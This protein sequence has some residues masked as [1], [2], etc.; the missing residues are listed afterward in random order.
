MQS[1]IFSLPRRYAAVFK[2]KH[3]GEGIRLN[4]FLNRLGLDYFAFYRMVQWLIHL[5]QEGI[6]SSKDV[7]DLKLEYG[8]YDAVA[9]LAEMMVNRQ[10]IGEV[11]AQGPFEL[12]D[13]LGIDATEDIQFGPGMA[14]GMT[15][16]ID[17]RETGLDPR[18]FADVVRPRPKHRHQ[19]TH[20]D[21][22]PD[23]FKDTYWP[24]RNRSFFDVKRDFEQTMTP[25]EAEI[26]KIFSDKSFNTGR[27]EKHAGDTVSVCNCLGI[28]DISPYT[29]WDP[30]RNI[31]VLAD[32]Y[33]AVTG[34]EMASQELKKI[35]ERAMDMERLLNVR[36]GFNREDDAFPKEWLLNTK[37]PYTAA[38]SRHYTRTGE[39]YLT[40]FMGKRL[41]RNDLQKMLDDYYDERGWDKDTGIPTPE[42]L[43]ELGLEEFVTKE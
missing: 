18:V 41:S 6:I 12:M 10:G 40:D 14:K 33:S 31:P 32:F 19:A 39:C 17:A 16:W 23:L 27:L 29:K 36:E 5:Y 3:Y 34:F 37:K 13:K 24:S 21:A 1:G 15:T 42:K 25:T 30:M 11:M 9:Q 2:F 22:G 43:V 35:G 4:D 28:C 26:K 7:G 8:N 38:I 20:Y